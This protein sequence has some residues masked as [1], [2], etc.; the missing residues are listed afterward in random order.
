VIAFTT[1]SFGGGP[2]RPL[3]VGGER[4]QGVLHPVSQLAED[5]LGDVRRIL[6]DEIHPH[7]LRADE[8]HH[9]LDLFEERL[10]RVRE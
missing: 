6:G 3:I 7:A 8:P 5:P 1:S 10:R 4:A 2:D 9:L